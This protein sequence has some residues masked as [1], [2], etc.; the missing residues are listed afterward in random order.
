MNNLFVLVFACS[1]VACGDKVS[2]DDVKWSLEAC[3][4]YGGLS[5]LYKEG[6]APTMAI[7][8]DDTQ[9]RRARS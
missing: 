5:A 1:L 2:V 9:V 4:P 6:R 3:K 8:L 7:C